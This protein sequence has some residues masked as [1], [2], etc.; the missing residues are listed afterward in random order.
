MAT[1]LRNPPFPFPPISMLKSA[2][3]VVAIAIAAITSQPLANSAEVKSINTRSNRQLFSQVK[4]KL[5]AKQVKVTPKNI[6]E[7]DLQGI[8]QAITER[9]ANKNQ[10]LEKAEGNSRR[11]YE[12]KNLKLISFSANKA[13][14]EVEENIRSYILTTVHSDP[15]KRS[16][17]NVS[18]NEYTKHVFNINLEKSAGKWKINK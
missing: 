13:Q 2:I 10:I 12:V 6:S 8:N 14:V 17:Q 5:I 3:I 11:F 15:Q 9:Y 16:F 18:D 7:R 1:V 4:A